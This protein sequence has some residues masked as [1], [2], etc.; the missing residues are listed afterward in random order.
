MTRFLILQY[1]LLLE[2][3]LAGYDCTLYHDWISVTN[4]DWFTNCPDEKCATYG[5]SCVGSVRRRSP[6]KI[7]GRR[8]PT[9]CDAGQNT[10]TWIIHLTRKQKQAQPNHPSTTKLATNIYIS[11]VSKT[12][13]IMAAAVVVSIGATL[14]TLL[15]ITYYGRLSFSSQAKPSDSGDA[16]DDVTHL[17][18]C[19][20]LM[21]S[22]THTHISLD[23]TY[24]F[25]VLVPCYSAGTRAVFLS[26]F[27]QLK[28]LYWSPLRWKILSNSRLC[29]AAR[30][31][32]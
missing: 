29:D 18:V 27:L 8:A 19:P 2:K 15:C 22:N 16:K 6:Q 7:D 21:S 14:W 9:Y 25:L 17:F 10:P 12:S 31:R 4:N 13:T 24:L 1:E 5:G 23:G 26:L 28:W 11:T 30:R 32:K 20:W 3:H